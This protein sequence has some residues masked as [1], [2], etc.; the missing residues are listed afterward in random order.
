MNQLSRIWDSTL[1]SGSAVYQID[2]CLYRFLYCDPYT[3]IQAPKYRF[4]PLSGQ[5]KRSDLVLNRKQLTIRC[6]EV[7][8]M[9][10]NHNASAADASIQ[11]GLF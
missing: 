11:L 1:L 9:K 2:G 3:S 6:Y 10:A 8:L 4:R 7:L 5:R